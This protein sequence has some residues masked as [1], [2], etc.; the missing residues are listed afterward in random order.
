[1]KKYYSLLIFLL[2]IITFNSRSQ[3]LQFNFDSCLIAY[4]PFNGN[5]NDESG[6]ANHG[7][8]Y[9]ANLIADRFG[10][11]NSAYEFNGTNTYILLPT[12]FDIPTKTINFWF[13]AYNITTTLGSIFDSDHP[14]LLYGKCGFSVQEVNG[15]N[16]LYYN[17]GGSSLSTRENLLENHWYMSTMVVKGDTTR[18]Y[19]NG[20]LFDTKY[21]YTCSVNGDTKAHLG[22]TRIFDRYFYGSIDDVRIYNCALEGPAINQLYN[23]PNSINTV[24]NK[25][26]IL[27]YPNPANDYIIINIEDYNSM[28]SY[29]LYI[30]NTLGQAVF[31]SP[32]NQQYF[33]ID[34]NKFGG[35]GL[36]FIKIVDNYS[37]IFHVTKLILQ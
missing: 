22:C 33:S 6:N 20:I 13:N 19:L 4:Y 12:D 34:V 2:L 17:R 35:L 29:T 11:I 23:E 36:Y 9:G 31:I 14:A 7:I 5:T 37:K 21:A 28:N 16:I 26:N 1:M 30:E 24:Q 18:Y 8:C 15:K 10:N 25:I 27:V 3:N 32:V